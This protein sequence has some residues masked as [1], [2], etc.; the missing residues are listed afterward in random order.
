M[1]KRQLITMSLLLFIGYV[2]LNAMHKE[3]G[4]LTP[5]QQRLARILTL[6]TP[7]TEDMYKEIISE[8]EIVNEH[9]QHFGKKT[10]IV[11]AYTK[12]EHKQKNTC[13]FFHS[14]GSFFKTNIFGS[15]NGSYSITFLPFDK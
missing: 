12:R 13:I 4:H 9:F 5:E 1:N 15:L 14:N 2:N 6:I 8:K 11:F 3:L 10:D 7:E